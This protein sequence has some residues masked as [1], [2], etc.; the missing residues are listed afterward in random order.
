MSQFPKNYEPKLNLHETES[1]I[2]A[3]KDIGASQ[4]HSLLVVVVVLTMI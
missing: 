3:V 2:K 1:A 4:V